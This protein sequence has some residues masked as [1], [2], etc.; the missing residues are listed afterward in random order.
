[1]ALTLELTGLCPNHR[2]YINSDNKLLF[3]TEENSR[4]ASDFKPTND[5]ISL[6]TC[7]L[8]IHCEEKAIEFSKTKNMPILYITFCKE[9][10]VCTMVGSYDAHLFQIPYKFLEPS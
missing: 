3:S 10:F 2:W 6:N 1:M 4:L 7:K 9:T 5:K 8:L